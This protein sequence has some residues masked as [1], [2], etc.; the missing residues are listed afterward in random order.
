[1]KDILKRCD[2]CNKLHRDWEHHGFAEQISG[3]N[4]LCASCSAEILKKWLDDYKAEEAAD[5]R[6]ENQ[7]I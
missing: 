7:N 1:M 2:I 3:K 4:N 5:D 6:A